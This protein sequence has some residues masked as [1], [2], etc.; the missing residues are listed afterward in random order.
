M[1]GK[2]QQKRIMIT[3]KEKERNVRFKECYIFCKG[4]KSWIKWDRAFSYIFI[5]CQIKV[6]Y[7]FSL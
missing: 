7:C 1:N 4:E 3:K 2:L 6:V 5:M